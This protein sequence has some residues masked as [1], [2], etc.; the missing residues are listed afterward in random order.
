MSLIALAHAT[1]VP[2][3]FNGAFYSTIA[4]I[5]PV[6]YLALAVQGRVF[7]DLLAAFT[8]NA[9]RLSKDPRSQAPGF[10]GTGL[11]TAASIPLLAATL[12]LIAGAGAEILAIIALY[13]QHAPAL[14]GTYVLTGASVLGVMI[15]V[16]P[17]VTLWQT[18][19][20]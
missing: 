5:V 9:D 17:A 15:V 13:D 19:G 3:P 10:P 7:T 12:I 20:Q 14:I 4:T 1:S 11:A 16:P 2:Q 6:M 18:L 8:A